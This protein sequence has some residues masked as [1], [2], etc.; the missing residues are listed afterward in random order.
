MGEP[1]TL[2]RALPEVAAGRD[3]TL[4]SGL[5]VGDYPF[6]PAVE[7]GDLRYETWHVMRPVRDL[8][9]SGVVPFIPA[10][11]S[12]IPGLL[13]RWGLGAAI[14]RVSPPG[15]DG[16]VSL[17][18][19]ASYSRTAIRAAQ[20]AIAEVDPSVPRTHGDTLVPVSAFDSLVET[21]AA[22]P[23]YHSAE[24]TA[25]TR[26]VATHL[27]ALLPQNPTIQIGVGAIPE[28][29]IHSLL[30]IDLGTLRFVGLA[31]DPMVD[32]FAAGVLR[33]DQIGP[34]PAILSPEMQCTPKL[35]EFLDD[36]PAVELH[37]SSL[38]HDA[39]LLGRIDRFISI[40]TAL[41]VDLHGNVNSEIVAGRQLS[42]TGGSID[43][44]EAAARSVGG[45]RIVALPSTS[46][47]GTRPRIV[48]GV[49]A[50]TIPRSMVDVIV[51]EHGS[52]VLTGLSSQART[53]AL[54][55]VA[56]PRHRD[57]LCDAVLSDAAQRRK[58]VR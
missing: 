32:L 1:T 23:E 17:G 22:L 27:L 50:V 4:C 56:D 34:E 42:G 9:A 35:L 37:P 8:V 38:A 13:E 49:E 33:H 16:T 52:A 12:A 48:A 6:L 54:I 36:N 11:A 14:V 24:A 45:L 3:W 57:A 7:A 26:Q 10:R 18:A 43:Y 55:A 44:G 47:D 46:P 29:L 30:D 25:L 20:V 31:I 40:N 41:E 53:E 39:A 58:V 21:E 5:M 28:A 2:L 51:T 19:S 15:R